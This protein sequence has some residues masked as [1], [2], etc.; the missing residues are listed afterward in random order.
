MPGYQQDTDS[1]RGTLTV[2]SPLEELP[3]MCPIDEESGAFNT[4]SVQGLPSPM[5]NP[6]ADEANGSVSRDTS[7][8][9]SKTVSVEGNKFINSSYVHFVVHL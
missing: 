9:N 8:H 5:E 7:S 3:V 6:V 1:E 2:N 4:Q